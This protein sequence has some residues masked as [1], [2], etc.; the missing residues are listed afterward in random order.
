MRRKNHYVIE[1]KFLWNS[2][3]ELAKTQSKELLR[4]LQD[5][6]KYIETN[7]LKAPFRVCF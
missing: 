2:I 5:G 6:F 4:T 3:A 1:P 7:R